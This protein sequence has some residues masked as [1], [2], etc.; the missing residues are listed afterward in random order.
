MFNNHVNNIFSV[1]VFCHY[2]VHKIC[3][4]N[5]MWFAIVFWSWTFISLRP[6]FLLSEWSQIISSGQAANQN[7][8]RWITKSFSYMLILCLNANFRYLRVILSY[9]GLVQCA[10]LQGIFHWFC[11]FLVSI[12]LKSH[13]LKSQRFF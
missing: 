9:S 4:K 1:E 10:M 5:F 12:C 2:N 8:L 6:T 13:Q 7:R 3:L 11:R